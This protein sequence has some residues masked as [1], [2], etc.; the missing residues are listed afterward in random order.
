MAWR[1]DGACWQAESASR[2]SLW[3]VDS[4]AWSAAFGPNGVFSGGRPLGKDTIQ[5]LRRRVA[6]DD[7]TGGIQQKTGREL[8]DRVEIGDRG[9]GFP[10]V[11][12]RKVRQMHGPR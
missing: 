7:D 2:M 11:D 10:E 3:V 6:G 4:S 5:G 8:A 9:V 1:F 12:P